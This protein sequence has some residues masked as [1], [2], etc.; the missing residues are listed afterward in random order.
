MDLGQREHG[1]FRK[2]AE[3]GEKPVG[4]PV[5]M[6]RIAHTAHGS[7]QLRP[8][9]KGK[10]GGRRQKPGIFPD[11]HVLLP[12]DHLFA[13]DGGLVLDLH[14][15]LLHSLV[16]GKSPVEVRKQANHVDI[17]RRGQLHARHGHDAIFPTGGKEGGTVLRR[18]VIRQRHDPEPIEIPHPRDVAGRH[19]LLPTG[20]QAGMDVQIYGKGVHESRDAT[21]AQSSNTDSGDR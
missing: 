6:G 7:D 10:G 4:L 20:R 9:L 17:L 14:P 12:H 18:I 5:N 21:F 13:E 15:P 11:G 19:I 8:F 1:L 3:H 2:G 16:K